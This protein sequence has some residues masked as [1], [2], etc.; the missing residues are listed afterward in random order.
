M[1]LVRQGDQLYVTPEDND[2]MSMKYASYNPEDDNPSIAFGTNGK[3]EY[4][5]I[6]NEFGNYVT[7]GLG[8]I[9]SFMQGYNE[10]GLTDWLSN[11]NMT[12]S[13]FV[14]SAASSIGS[15]FGGT[16]YAADNIGSALNE[17][18]N[19]YET[20]SFSKAFSSFGFDN[21]DVGGGSSGGGGSADFD[22]PS[23]TWGNLGSSLGDFG[24]SGGYDFSVGN[25]FLDDQTFSYNNNSYTMFK[26]EDRITLPNLP[27]YSFGASNIGEVF[28]GIGDYLL[29]NA[30][31]IVD[32]INAQNRVSPLVLDLNNNGIETTALYETKVFFDIDADGF[33]EKVGWVKPTEGL[34]A[35]DTNNNGKI[36]DITE[37]F[38]DDKQPAFDKLRRFDSNHDGKINASDADYSKLLVWQDLN[39]DGRTD[40]GELKTLQ[41]AGVKEI[42]LTETKTDSY[43]N[44]NYISTSATFTKFDNSTSQIADV[45]FMN[46]NTNTWFMGAQTLLLPLSRG[47]GSLPSLHIA[48]TNDAT[49][50]GMMRE[51]TSLSPLPNSVEYIHASLN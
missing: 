20:S 34:L 21:F 15:L 48:M 36:D 12:L 19:T 2:F 24:D 25:A 43:Q 41:E 10:S 50:K 14:D 40:S 38:G 27:A 49:L 45:H 11:N 17:N 47:Y 30:W 4:N 39:T 22:L 26:Q 33:A 37:L 5:N 9:G 29:R 51:I 23:A 32:Y 44:D 7:S 13:N 3:P 1:Y 46:D 16:A 35:I 42:S 18:Y 31:A 28:R 6:L 8:S